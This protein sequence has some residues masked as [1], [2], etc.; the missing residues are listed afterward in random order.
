LPPLTGSIH[1]I[2]LI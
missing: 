2:F 1:G